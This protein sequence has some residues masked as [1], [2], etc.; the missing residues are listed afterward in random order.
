MPCA[1][2]QPPAPG[3]PTAS[4]CG[5]SSGLLPVREAQVA[6]PAGEN[7]VAGEKLDPALLS[8]SQCIFSERRPL[9]VGYEFF[10][11]SLHV[12]GDKLQS[13]KNCLQGPR[14]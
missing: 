4:G 12:D 2:S 14:P 11:M 3:L 1:P 13:H 10:T 7:E 9:I 6:L 8:S 5:R